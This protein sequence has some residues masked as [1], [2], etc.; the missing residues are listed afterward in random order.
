VLDSSLSFIEDKT[1]WNGTKITF[2]IAKKGDRTEVRFTH[3]GLGPENECFDG[4]F[5]A[6]DSY[7]NESLR[8]LIA[9]G[10]GQPNPKE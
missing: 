5:S 7:I 6:W 4:C 1:E 10:K 2:E 3:V 9:T 8:S